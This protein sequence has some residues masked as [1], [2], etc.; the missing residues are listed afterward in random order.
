M[1]TFPSPCL[2]FNN[3]NTFFWSKAES[4][5]CWTDS[6]S[7]RWMG[8]GPKASGRFVILAGSRKGP[9]PDLLGW[10]TKMVR[11]MGAAKARFSWPAGDIE[12]RTSGDLVGEGGWGTERC[13]H[14]V[15]C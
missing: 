4:T 15:N 10:I 8:P 1:I 5:R 14:L 12:S 2:G 6:L 13:T 11:S 3:S 9:H 7:T